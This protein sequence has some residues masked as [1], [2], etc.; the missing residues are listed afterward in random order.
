MSLGRR[1]IIGV[2]GA[3]FLIFFILFQLAKSVALAN[4]VVEVV[5][6]D[7][8]LSDNLFVSQNSVYAPDESLPI[9]YEFAD[10]PYII[11]LPNAN[12]ADVGSGHI[13][14]INDTMVVYIAQV[15]GSVDV[16]AAVLSQ[17]PKVVYLN[18][19]KDNSY[20]MTV[21]EQS[22][23]LNGLPTTYFVDHLLISTGQGADAKNAY[24]LGYCFW[25]ET[26]TGD[27][28]LVSIATIE[29]STENFA[30]CKQLLDILAYTTRYDEKLD[31]NQKDERAKIA[32][33]YE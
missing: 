5:Y 22:G 13:V 26:D 23:Y 33:E 11:D 12:T 10:V 19:S 15:P 1:I 21:K 29:E 16:H 8:G 9:A 2:S 6:P 28:I 32:R 7:G 31:K 14:Q 24:V 17:Y 20:S 30:N 4:E 27:K 25:P 3:L 18:Y